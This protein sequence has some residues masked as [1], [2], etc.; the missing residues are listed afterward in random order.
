MPLSTDENAPDPEKQ[1][2]VLLIRNR[3]SRILF[4]RKLYDY[5]ISLKG[6]TF[7]NLGFKNIV[8]I[9]FSYIHSRIFPIKTERSLEDFLVNRFGRELYLI[10]FKAYTEKVWGVPCDKIKPEWGS[11]RIKG[12]SIT[13]AVIHALKKVFKNDR[14][15][16]QKHTETSLIEQFG[17]PKYGP[18]QLWEAVADQIVKRGGEIHRETCVHGINL[19][20]NQIK[21]VIVKN[22]RTNATR[23]EY[24]D[25]LFSCMPVKYLISSISSDVPENVCRVADGLLYRDFMTVGLLLEKMKIKNDTKIPS[26]NNFIPDNW[27]YIQ[28]RDVKLGRLQIYNNW[29][30][31]MLEDNNKIWLGLEY[32]CNKGDELWSMP[33]DVFKKFA[34]SELC[35]IGFIDKE[36]VLDSTLIRMPKTY[37]AYFGTY[38]EFDVI[39][40]YTNK[41][42]NLFL[43]GRNGMHKYNNAD[44]A[45]LTAITAVDNIIAGK[46]SKE[47]IW[48]VNTE[49]EYHE[50][51]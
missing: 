2:N 40:N 43:I 23:E 22:V 48:Q 44:H 1:D 39:K 50:E 45:M 49:T 30:P 36:D 24:C 37:P 33:D 47:N 29:S 31:Y 20:D 5:P 21:S 27:I 4:L 46:T 8:K 38:D 9:G 18:G 42:E 25:Y 3:L 51:K 12:L 16:S 26:L 28:E 14:S 15:I 41:I 19:S 32:F 10:F 17:Y 34:V 11:Q 13:K 35:K 7:K 6:S